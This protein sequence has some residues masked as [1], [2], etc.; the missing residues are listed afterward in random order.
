MLQSV[1]FADSRGACPDDDRQFDFPVELAS[2]PFVVLDR[3]TGADH[4]GWRLREDDGLLGQ[5][6]RRVQR[7]ARFSHVLDVI[8]SDAEDVLARARNRR[9]QLHVGERLRDAGGPLAL[10]GGE[11]FARGPKRL[12]PQVDEPEHVGRQGLS[13]ARTQMSQVDY[14]IIHQRSQ[15]RGSAHLGAICHKTHAILR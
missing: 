11:K 1:C 2:D 3:I 13:G 7:A 10:A 8:Q 6:L 9:Q 14:A 12:W 4:G 5:L 15:S